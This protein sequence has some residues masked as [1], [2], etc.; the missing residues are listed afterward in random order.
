MLRL[1]PFDH[2]SIEAPPE[3]IEQ[4]S[5]HSDKNDDKPF[6]KTLEIAKLVIGSYYSALKP[7]EGK[8][9]DFT[10]D[11]KET[12]GLVV[13]CRNISDY[14]PRIGPL[15]DCRVWPIYDKIKILHVF[16]SYY[17]PRLDIIGV[18]DNSRITAYKMSEVKVTDLSPLKD[19]FLN[20]I[21]KRKWY[22]T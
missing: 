18:V 22:M 5:Q 6:K 14:E 2:I 13:H 17:L 12:I 4:V 8:R 1:Y 19:S 10:Y 15:Y 16:C 21:D 7:V 3:L 9:Y 11:G 20:A